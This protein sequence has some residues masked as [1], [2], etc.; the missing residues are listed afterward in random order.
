MNAY[1]EYS[2]APGYGRD[3]HMADEIITRAAGYLGLNGAGDHLLACV[4]LT[5]HSVPMGT[6][7]IQ[8]P[9]ARGTRRR[10]ET[11]LRKAFAFMRE[12]KLA[13][14][15]CIYVACRRS[16]RI[17]AGTIVGECLYTR[18]TVLHEIRHGAT[19]VIESTESEEGLEDD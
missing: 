1:Y 13:R 18:P 5:S 8:L 7:T 15:T 3:D 16:R 6:S 19:W 9:V 14:D 11:A 2:H 10:M 17:K 4:G 12:H